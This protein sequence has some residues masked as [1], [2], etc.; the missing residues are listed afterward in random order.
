MPYF[1]VDDNL[2]AH[3]K[4]DAAGLAAM[5]L[6][7]LAGSWS[8][9]AATGGFVP[10]VRVG[11]LGGTKALAS[12]LVAAGFWDV[13][14]GGYRF[15]DWEDQ[16]GNADAETEKK[17]KA[18]NARRQRE[19]RARNASRNAV[20]DVVTND[21]PS[22]SPRKTDVTTL[23]PVPPEIPAR[24]GWTDEEIRSA[25]RTA[26]VRDLNHVIVTVQR[27]TGPIAHIAM[28]FDLIRAVQ[29]LSLKP[30]KSTDAYL[31]AACLN[32]PA[33]IE[34]EW[35]VVCDDWSSAIGAAKAVAS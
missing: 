19:W 17:R 14:E 35:R 5:G 3:P 21:A 8:K 10:A 29:R 34:R 25:C 28:L 26:H 18:D 11:K 7:T 31:D 9:H 23:D 15:H 33:E 30:I 12:K 4:V 1:P 24:D 6:W 32:S 16:A 22:P 27:V 20:T 13:V 2:H